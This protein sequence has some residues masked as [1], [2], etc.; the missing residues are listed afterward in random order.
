VER[1]RPQRRRARRWLAIPLA[2]VLA[3][4]IAFAGFEIGRHHPP[5]RRPVAVRPL[6]DPAHA[7]C[8]QVGFGRKRFPRASPAYNLQAAGALAGAYLDTGSDPRVLKA[9]FSLML[10]SICNQTL[11]PTYQ[12][13]TQARSLADRARDLSVQTRT[14]F[15]Q[16]LI[17]L[18]GTE[19]RGGEQLTADKSFTHQ[20]NT[21]CDRAAVQIK[22]LLRKLSD[23]TGAFKTPDAQTL[24]P[25]LD[26]LNAKLQDL[27][28]HSRAANARSF[29]TDFT[30]RV[31]AIG[32][33]ATRLARLN[34]HW[35]KNAQRAAFVASGIAQKQL[36]FGP[37]TSNVHDCGTVFEPS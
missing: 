9:G 11:D 25:L 16:T 14:D 29:V 3:A 35:K 8:A 5:R 6:G 37:S 15:A 21:V 33:D 19:A 4:A 18:A 20:A 24:N 34:D 12:P 10:L 7:T 28:S 1:D 32:R 27:A 30:G 31:Q 23:P 17:S 36:D 2:L 13:E 26:G 22:P